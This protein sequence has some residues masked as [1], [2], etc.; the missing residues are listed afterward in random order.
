MFDSGGDGPQLAADDPVA[1]AL[2]AV[3]E[4][5]GEDLTAL[6]PRAAC[7]RMR[8]IVGLL[9]RVEATVIGLTAQWDATGAW[10]GALPPALSPVAWLAGNTHM[11]RSRA[12]CLVR[13]ADLVRRF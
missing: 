9:E 4:L 11:S 2:S 12:S 10:A 6:L 8:E 3:A 13:G 7:D 5:A 1:R